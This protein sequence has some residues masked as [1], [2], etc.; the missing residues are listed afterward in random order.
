VGNV[1]PGAC[2][3]VASAA[4]SLAATPAAAQPR[5]I[6]WADVVGLV[7][8]HPLLREAG[9]RVAAAE[10]GVEAAGAVPNPSLEVAFGRGAP[11]EGTGSARFE[12]SY[13]LSVPLD[14]LAQRG[15]R[16]EA[17]R[18]GVDEAK[19]EGRARRRE[20]LVQLGGLYWNAAFDQARVDSLEGLE[21]Q[22][23]EVAKLVGLRVQKGEARPIEIPRIETELERV[24]NELSA[25]RSLLK[26][27]RGQ[28]QLWIQGLAAADWRIEAGA[29]E[30]LPKVAQADA[31]AVDVGE[32]H[33]ALEAS[34]ARLRA[35][36]AEA[37]L[38]RRQRIPSFSVKGFATD[39]LDRQAF[40]GGLGVTLPVWN[41]N[42]GR[43][44]QVEAAREAA[45]WRLEAERRSLS[46]DATEARNACA[47][48]QEAA[49]RYRDAILP[50]AQSAATML[51]R[52]FQIGEATLLDV[53]DARRVLGDTRRGYLAA[54]LQAQLDCNRLQLLAGEAP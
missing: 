19:A 48:G 23:A 42:S 7:E 6:S 41:W 5:A 40:G 49:Q 24:R 14:W 12:Q 39:E 50:M 25:A 54:L 37:T 35:L 53:L 22:T 52:S 46:A 3:L 4:M 34:R 28:L 11:R 9:S 29:L 32:A 17:A 44:A 2:A 13:E 20:I 10:A 33:P 47:Q 43:I 45:K 38:E 16:V 36:E 31:T 30:A 21:A 8:G 15:P 26:T 51:E 1:L 27:H 18:S